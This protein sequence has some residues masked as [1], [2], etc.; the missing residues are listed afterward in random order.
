MINTI[1]D[2]F[3]SPNFPKHLG[4]PD[5]VSI[6][7]THVQLATNAAVIK[8]THNGGHNGHLIL[9][10]TARQYTLI[11]QVPFF[12][13]A[14]PGRTST[15]PEWTTPF[16][17]KT[18]IHEHTDQ[19]QQYDECCNVNSALHNQPLTSFENTHVLPLKKAFTGYSGANTLSLLIH[20]YSNYKRIS[21]TDLND[22]NKKLR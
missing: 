14:E 4:K 11:S 20:L 21:A 10:L 8:S 19:H 15:I 5:Y 9:V 7:D 16:N 12:Q 3:P 22:N 13:P 17:K 1:T 18:L 2:S 6:Q